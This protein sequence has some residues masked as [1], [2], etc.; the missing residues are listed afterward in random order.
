MGGDGTLNVTIGIGMGAVNFAIGGSFFVASSFISSGDQKK[1]YSGSVFGSRDVDDVEILDGEATLFISSASGFQKKDRS[2][3]DFV[4][5][6]TGD[7]MNFVG[8]AIQ[9]DLPC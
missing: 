9:R 6:V 4:S 5:G 8:G 1:E 3:T 2:E 7:E